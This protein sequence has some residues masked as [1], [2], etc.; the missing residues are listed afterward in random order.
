MLAYFFLLKK[1]ASWNHHAALMGQ[2]VPSLQI[3]KCLTDIYEIWCEGYSN[4]EHPNVILLNLIHLLA[5]KWRTHELVRP[6]RH[7]GTCF[8]VLKLNTGVLISP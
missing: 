8:I 7:N 4:S 2:H 6:E 5:T 3:L 1:Q